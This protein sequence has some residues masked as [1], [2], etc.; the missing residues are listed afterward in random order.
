MRSPAGTR[1]FAPTLPHRT[2]PSVHPAAPVASAAAPRSALPEPPVDRGAPTPTAPAAHALGARAA[3]AP[4]TPSPLP[5]GIGPSDRCRTGCAPRFCGVAPARRGAFPASGAS[6]AGPA[7]AGAG[8]S[9]MRPCPLSGPA[10]WPARWQR[11][12]ASIPRATRGPR[13]RAGKSRWD[14]APVGAARR[15]SRAGARLPKPARP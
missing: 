9:A 8:G 7:P 2:V 14:A 10:P 4:A 6:M 3:R 5:G 12:P 11:W 1:T 15:E 13:N